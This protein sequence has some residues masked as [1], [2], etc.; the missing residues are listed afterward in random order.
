[1]I[2]P[3]D[4]DRKQCKSLTTSERRIQ[5]ENLSIS[6]RILAEGK[7]SQQS[8]NNIVLP[9]AGAT[10]RHQKDNKYK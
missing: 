4:A 3:V 2:Q 7:R 9:D 8:I 10:A 5:L 1:M 6:L